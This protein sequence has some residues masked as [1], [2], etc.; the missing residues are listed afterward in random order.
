MVSNFL[1]LGLEE[2]EKIGFQEHMFLEHHLERWCPWRGPIRHFM[3][4]LEEPLPHSGA[5]KGSHNVVQELL[6]GE[7]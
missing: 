4:S 6:R 1:F 5:E 3:E 7:T 2:E